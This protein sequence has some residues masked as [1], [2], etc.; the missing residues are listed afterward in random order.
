M[1]KLLLSF[2]LVLLTPFVFSENKYSE[3][4]LK[5]KELES[6]K[7]WVSALA[8]YWDAMESEPTIKSKEAY[9][10]YQR[11]ANAIKQGN[12][13]LGSYD[14]FNFHDEWKNLQKDYE[15]YWSKNCARQFFFSKIQRKSRN[16]NNRTI[17]YSISLDSKLTQKFITITKT[18]RSGYEKAWEN[19]WDMNSNWLSLETKIILDPENDPV[20]KHQ[21]LNNINNKKRNQKSLTNDDY[22][23]QQLAFD[24]KLYSINFDVCNLEDTVILNGSC[25]SGQTSDFLN[26]EKLKYEILDKQNIKVKP[27]SVLLNYHTIDVKNIKIN[28]PYDSNPLFEENILEK[29]DALF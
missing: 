7:L 27:T 19:D 18:I 23:F 12:P 13:G 21:L 2:I 8:A 15:N 29:L 6:K 26:I 9:S 17:N 14:E 24:E 3:N 10:S 4:L 16:F 1:K 20:L 22:T 11:I 25:K 5:A 28:T